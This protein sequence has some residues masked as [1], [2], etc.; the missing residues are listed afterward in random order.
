M[1]VLFID[2]DTLRPDHMGCYGYHRNTTP[3]LDKVA[4]D[5]VIFNKYYCSDAPCLP[6][7]AALVSGKFGIRNGAVDH[8]GTCSDMRLNGEDRQFQNS[9]D[10]DSFN[11]LFKKAGYYTTSISTF[12]DRHSA[13]WFN[14]KYN[15]TYNVGGGGSES[16]EK[17]L[18]VALDWLD[19]NKDRENWFLHVHFWDPHTPYRVPEECGNPFEN[20][21][22]P[23][24][25]T[26]D[27]F[28]EHLKHVGPHSANEISMF[29]DKEDPRFPRQPGKIA[30]MKELKDLMDGYDCGIYYADYLI[31]KIIDKLKEQNIYE[32][33]AIMITSDHGENMGELGIYSEH[34]TADHAT[35]NIPMIVKWP[36]G[37]KNHVDNSLHYNIDIVPTVAD[38]LSLEQ[39][40]SWDGKSYA[41]AIKNG[42]DEGHEYLVISQMAHVCQRSARFGD[43]LYVRTYHDGYHLFDKEMLYNIT[44]DPYE[45]KDVKENYPE[46]CAKGAK[47]ILDWHDEM[48][49]KSDSTID[50]LWTV[51]SEGG[52]HHA[53]GRLEKYLERLEATGRNEG[54]QKLKEKYELV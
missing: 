32:D 36:G 54:A 53:K 18:P 4:S 27:V 34:A 21:P 40:K 37:I 17:V 26:E 20:E 8:G 7:R 19:R 51:L 43:W 41:K 38:L 10:L 49:M 28:N 16:G 30:N 31:R 3:N 29:D 11:N 15:E 33:T 47:Y 35:C 50:P 44:N 12:A 25:L 14:A 39:K 22:I 45:T 6:S 42:E 23:E 13:W 1:N 9:Y 52:P 46:I 2:I 5:G 24:W 48:M